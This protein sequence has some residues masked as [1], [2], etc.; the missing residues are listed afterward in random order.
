MHDLVT[1]ITNQE[2][3][4]FLNSGAGHFQGPARDARQRRRACRSPRTVRVALII[5]PIA[6]HAIQVRR[7]DWNTSASGLSKVAHG[8]Q[9][10]L[11]RRLHSSTA[12][13]S[14]GSV[15]EADIHAHPALLIFQ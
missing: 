15:F 2:G 3:P 1:G 11:N 12:S 8:T 14:G 4:P 10:S 9:G 5:C 6:P 7:Q 13:T